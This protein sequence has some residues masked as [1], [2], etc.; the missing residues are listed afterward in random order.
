MMDRV[1]PPPTGPLRSPRGR[2]GA[3]IAL[4]LILGMLMIVAA[5]TGAMEVTSHG[6]RG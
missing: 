3:M 4:T 1:N 6:V 5:G 2:G